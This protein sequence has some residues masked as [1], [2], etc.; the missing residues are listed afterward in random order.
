MELNDSDGYGLAMP[1]L[2]K[3]WGNEIGEDFLLPGCVIRNSFCKGAVFPIDFQ[4]FANDNN[5]DYITDVWGNTYDINNVELILTES[6]LK[7]WD[8]YS[9]IEDYLE[10]CKNNN[11]M[12]ELK[13]ITG[14]INTT[15][16]LCI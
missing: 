16:M 6:M 5:I 2:M 15:Q 1:C 13:S 8:S 14:L 3:R 10:N 9:S 12:E 4:K 7:L 11:Y